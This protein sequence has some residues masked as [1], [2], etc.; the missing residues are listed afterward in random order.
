MLT[1]VEYF[2][3]YW[4]HVPVVSDL[5]DSIHQ[6]RQAAAAEG[7]SSRNAGAYKPHLSAHTLEQALNSGTAVQVCNAPYPSMCFHVEGGS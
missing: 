7:S 6:S 5:Y 2:A 3:Q 1:S 4:G